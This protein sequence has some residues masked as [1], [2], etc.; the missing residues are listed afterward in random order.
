[1]KFSDGKGWCS[2]LRD[3]G[4]C[5]VPLSAKL[6]GCLPLSKRMLVHVTD[7]LAK[8]FNHYLRIGLRWF[9]NL[10]AFLHIGVFLSYLVD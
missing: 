7:R 3:A 10:H 6:R 5:C 4:F 8:F 2:A 1:M 9:E